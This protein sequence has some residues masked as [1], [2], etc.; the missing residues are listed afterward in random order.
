MLFR[1]SSLEAIATGAVTVAF[2]RWRKPSVKP[3]TNLRTAIGVLVVDRVDIVDESALTEEDAIAAGFASPAGL[4]A[5]LAQHPQGALYRISFHRGGPDPRLALRA[6]DALSGDEVAALKQ[7]LQ[8]MDTT[9]P[10]GPWTAATLALIAHHPATRAANLA[11]QLGR[12]RLSFKADVRKL[13]ELGLTESLEVG[14]RLSPRGR[15]LFEMLER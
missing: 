10:H 3:G 5:E 12:E 4:L 11:Q 15:A 8:R 9:S 13:K 14:Y 1:Q 6:Q 7:R 2:R